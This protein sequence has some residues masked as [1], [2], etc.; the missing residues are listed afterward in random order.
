[1]GD[2]GLGSV[3]VCLP[4]G[5][6]LLLGPRTA[7]A[8]IF[9][10]AQGAFI[11]Q[12]AAKTEPFAALSDDCAGDVLEFIEL[13]MPSAEALH[14]AT[15]CSSPE[16]CAWVRAVTAKAVVVRIKT[17]SIFSSIFLLTESI[18]RR[19]TTPSFLSSWYGFFSTQFQVTT[20]LKYAAK[21]GDL[22]AV[23]DC[24]PKGANVDAQS[25]VRCYV[26]ITFQI[27]STS[28][29]SYSIW[30]CGSRILPSLLP[31]RIKYPSIYQNIS[32]LFSFSSFFTPCLKFS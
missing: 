21:K 1:M 28:F 27:F 6:F 18:S 13:G 2:A 11:V 14:I 9:V 15:H 19:Y 16:A 5:P 17:R 25:E 12:L 24:L 4:A 7:R 3:L 26:T 10:W 23:Q 29:T 32:S 20:E 22:A 8:A 30:K 31:F